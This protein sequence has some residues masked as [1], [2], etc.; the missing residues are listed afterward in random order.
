MSDKRCNI[1]QE[2]LRWLL[3]KKYRQVLRIVKENITSLAM[4]EHA[5]W[6]VEKLINGFEPLTLKEHN[7]DNIRFGA[8]RNSYRKKLK[9]KAHHI[10]LGSYQELRRINPSDMKYDCFLTMAMIRILKERYA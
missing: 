9:N 6:N 4:C 1:D 10:D 5:R 2:T 7:E 3:N 8:S